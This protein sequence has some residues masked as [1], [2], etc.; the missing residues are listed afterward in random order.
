MPTLRRDGYILV[1]IRGKRK[2]E[3]RYVME[4]YLKR[5]LQ[6]EENVHH[7][8]HNRS[9]NRIENLK[10]YKTRAE[11]TLSEKHRPTLKYNPREF[12]RCIGCNKKFYR[13]QK[14]Y[15]FKKTKF[16]SHK[17]FMMKNERNYHGFL[18]ST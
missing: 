7:I 1:T 18:Q 8:N 2:F 4:Q 13:F 10:L 5:P 9:D 15:K 12:K 17:C 14:K 16:C 3:H 6:G 11:H